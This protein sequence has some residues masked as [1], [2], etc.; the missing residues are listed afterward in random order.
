M[1]S[2]NRWFPSQNLWREETEGARE[3]GDRLVA[4]PAPWLVGKQ[5]RRGQRSPTGTAGIRGHPGQSRVC[6]GEF[7]STGQ[8][9]KKL[10]PI[11]WLD[12][13]GYLWLYAAKNLA[14]GTFFFFL[15]ISPSLEMSRVKTVSLSAA[16]FWL[17][18]LLIHVFMSLIQQAL[19][20]VQ[21]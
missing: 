1:P 11:P 21:S 4:L 12:H 3:A 5:P 16:I 18:L 2:S 6:H 7:P 17:D 13:P 19:M 8:A 20:L 10:F 15:S 14:M 9:V